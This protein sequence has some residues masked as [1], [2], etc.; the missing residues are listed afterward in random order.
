MRL[1]P[2]QDLLSRN[3]FWRKKIGAIFFSDL[4]KER[5]KKIEF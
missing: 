1:T 4:K 3:H 2:G 5:K